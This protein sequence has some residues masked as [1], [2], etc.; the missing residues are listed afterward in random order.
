MCTGE[1]KWQITTKAAQILIKIFANQKKK[2]WNNKMNQR[3]T[4]NDAQRYFWW[5]ATVMPEFQL[6]S[7]CMGMVSIVPRRSK[8]RTIISNRWS[9]RQK[10]THTYIIKINNF[11]RKFDDDIS[12]NSVSLSLF[13]PLSLS[14]YVSVSL[15][16]RIQKVCRI[17]RFHRLD[18]VWPIG[19]WNIVSAVVVV[20]VAC[21][22]RYTYS[23]KKERELNLQWKRPSTFSFFLFGAHS[24]NAVKIA[25]SSWKSVNLIPTRIGSSFWFNSR[26]TVY[27]KL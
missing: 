10:C 15:D 26:R 3:L 1:K 23:V 25:S 12:F 13:L 18:F 9:D 14:P 11:C 17:K 7:V 20:L 8:M 6:F 24:L 16:S 22:W 2:T 21:Y 5:L 27:T 4:Q 19:Y